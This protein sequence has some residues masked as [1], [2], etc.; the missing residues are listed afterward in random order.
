MRIAVTGSSGLIGS[1]L[2]PALRAD[3]HDVLRLVRRTPRTGDEHRWDPQHHRIDPAVLADVD[4][5]LNLAGTPIRPRP[6]TARY[7]RS[8]VDSRLDSTRTIVE[9]FAAVAA[10]D[11]GRHR[12]LLSGSAV[13]YYGDAGDRRIDESAPAG[14]DFLAELCARW[15]AA[16][17]PAEAAGI[18]VVLLRTGLV[19][20]R[21]AML[22]DVLGRVFRAGLGGRFGSGRQY[23]PWI[24][25]DD[26]V[27][28]IR[29]LLTGDVAGPV[30]LTA[31]CPV[32][33]EEFTRAL[34][35]VVHRPTLLAV[36][37]FAISLGLGEFGR[38][39]VLAGQRAEPAKLTAAGFAFRHSDVESA[40][41]EA[42]GPR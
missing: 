32:T 12:V 38:S 13:G 35:R 23:W 33:N 42:L 14:Q 39:S 4:V 20:G 18:R 15:E 34:G 27:E 7:K 16:T 41:R 26:E 1:S 24:S 3:G 22:T 29:F 31:P 5:V 11:P 30:N 17:A 6:W 25:L 28:A 10:A 2:V 9:A 37:G 19:L 40:L 21:G 36:P 8:L